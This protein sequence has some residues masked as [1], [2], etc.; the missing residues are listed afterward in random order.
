[1]AL[2]LTNRST[3]MKHC[4]VIIFLHLPKWNPN[5]NFPPLLP[6]PWQPPATIHGHS[7]T[8]PA[9]TVSSSSTKIAAMRDEQIST[10][11]A[12]ARPVHCQKPPSSRTCRST[13]IPC[14]GH[15]L[16]P[17]ENL[18]ATSPSCRKPP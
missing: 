9:A 5:P 13:Y 6:S 7:R 10:V 16:H 4:H 17:C 11:L 2:I 18:E 3:P 14:G 8:S 12:P 15:H 1:M